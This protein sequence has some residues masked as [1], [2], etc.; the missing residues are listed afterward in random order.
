[1]RRNLPPFAALRAF[2]AAARHNS[3]K[4][5]AEDIC[6]SASAISHQVRSLEEY[7]GVN[8]FIREKGKPQL[9]SVGAAY[10]E[11]IQDILGQLDLATSEISGRGRRSS[12]VVNLLPSLTSCWLLPRLSV[13]QS[14]NPDVDIKLLGS[15]TPQEFSSGDI[16]LAIRYGHGDWTG[17]ISDFLFHDELFLVCSPRQ[18]ADLPPTDRLHELSEHTLIHC[19]Q[20][21]AEWQQWFELA[22]GGE[23][24][25]KHRIDLDSRALVLDAVAEE[26]GIAIGRTPFANDHIENKRLCD[27]Y[28]L[29]MRTGKGYYL[30][31]PEHHAGY[32]NVAKFRTWLLA[33]S[34]QDC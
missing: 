34:G 3:F 22:G 11:K 31:Y 32:E 27:P 10:L 24:E 18:V 16:D 19:S 1:M 5:A 13:Y 12:L 26:L 21:P 14:V 30:V 17:M 23:L 2:E 9:T 25:I 33:E 6:L 29:R 15:Y 7:L 8:L 28:H 4:M 20:H